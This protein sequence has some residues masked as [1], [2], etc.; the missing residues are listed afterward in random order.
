M[1]YAKSFAYRFKQKFG[2][3]W[4]N[5][6]VLL[7]SV[8]IPLLDLIFILIPEILQWA[9]NIG[10][11]SQ[12]TIHFF[13]ELRLWFYTQNVHQKRP[14]HTRHTQKYLRILFQAIE[15]KILCAVTIINGFIEIVYVQNKITIAFLP[16]NSNENLIALSQADK[17]SNGDLCPCALSFCLQNEKIARAIKSIS[18]NFHTNNTPL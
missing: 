10:N 16:A 4:N 18:V 15:I 9:V 8:P 17:A 13:L 1:F 5:Y 3:S 12:K 6:I 11:I 14:R 2:R 7:L